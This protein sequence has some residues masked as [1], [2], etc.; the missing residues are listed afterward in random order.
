V[1]LQ[2]RITT[3]VQQC[4]SG[5]D[6]AGA[7]CRAE[8]Q[9][10]AVKVSSK[11]SQVG[12]MRLELSSQVLKSPPANSASTYGSSQRRQCAELSC[13][14]T[15]PA[16]GSRLQSGASVRNVSL[17]QQFGLQQGASDVEHMRVMLSFLAVVPGATAPLPVW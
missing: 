16:A 9:M 4:C 12:G 1:L 7:T 3:A 14:V 5:T 2:R 17:K 15:Q 8:K 11:E 10:G 13:F 6:Q